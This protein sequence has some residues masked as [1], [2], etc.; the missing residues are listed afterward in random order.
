MKFRS[1]AVGVAAL[2]LAAIAGVVV[3]QMSQLPADS[4]SGHDSPIDVGG[5]SIYGSVGR[6]NLN[7][8]AEITGSKLYGSRSS[9]SDYI[10]LSGFSPISSPTV[11]QNTGGWLITIVT[12]D[13]Q[14]NPLQTP[15]ISFCSN[16]TSSAPYH[17]SGTS[18]N[19]DRRVY[20][21]ITSSTAQWDPKRELPTF[22]E[23]LYFDDHQPGCAGTESACDEI[24]SLTITTVNAISSLPPTDQ[25]TGP[26][27][28]GPFTCSV[29]A[30][31]SIET[32]Q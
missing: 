25:K 9:N 16:L 1:L 4:F 2:A 27:T 31:C 29:N 24:A 8:W 15:S 13:S 5:G 26:Y 23:R 20:L 17:C 7:K 32:G 10:K 12:K 19:S 30:D 21:E 22:K 28:Y 14:R 6:W 3:L 18:L 11:I